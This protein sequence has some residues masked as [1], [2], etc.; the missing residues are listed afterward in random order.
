MTTRRIAYTGMFIALAVALGF[1]LIIIPN[2][3]LVTA[4]VFISGWLLG[5]FLGA[6]VGLISEMI[7]SG[8]NPIGSGFLFFPLLLAQVL[9]MAITG[10]SGGILRRGK[11]LFLS[12]WGGLLALAAVGVILTAIF[13]LFTTLAFPIAAGFSGVQIWTILTAGSIFS[14]LHI[15][16][17]GAIFGIIV[18]GVLKSVYTQLGITEVIR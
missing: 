18:P 17:N 9:A 15:L 10:F 12:S 8:L 6:F 16:S 4:T 13:D 1:T 5:P 2:L 3:E 7:F 14:V 11:V